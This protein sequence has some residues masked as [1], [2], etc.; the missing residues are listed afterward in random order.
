MSSQVNKH[1]VAIT[2]AVLHLVRIS[3]VAKQT[4]DVCICILSNLSKK[5]SKVCGTLGPHY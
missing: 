4:A 2:Y 3:T 1:T 5:G